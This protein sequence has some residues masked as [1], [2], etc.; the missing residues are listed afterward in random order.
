MIRMS[1]SPIV[2]S[3]RRRLSQPLW[4]FAGA[5]VN[6][7]PTPADVAAVPADLRSAWVLQE[8]VDYAPALRSVDGDDVKLEMRMMYV[9]PD[10]HDRMTLL[11]NLM[12]LSRGKMMGVDYNKDLSWTGASVGLW[13]A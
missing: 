9:R 11:L 2:G 5:G 1:T 4:S 6:V 8:K 3:R 10:D 7:D 12:R 13:S